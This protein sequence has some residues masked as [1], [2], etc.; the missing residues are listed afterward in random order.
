MW[1]M[2]YGHNGEYTPCAINKWIRPQKTNKNTDARFLWANQNK[3]GKQKKDNA[4]RQPTA[5]SAPL[6]SKSPGDQLVRGHEGRERPADAFMISQSFPIIYAAPTDVTEAELINTRSQPEACGRLCD[7]SD[8]GTLWTSH[9]L[10]FAPSIDV[11]QWNIRL[12]GKRFSWSGLTHWHTF[13][14]QM[15]LR[16]LLTSLLRVFFSASEFLLLFSKRKIKCFDPFSPLPPNS[17]SSIFSS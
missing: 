16:R 2:Q 9:R 12:Q 8:V 1:P 6:L 4:S 11:R 17:R 14:E 7:L 3:T 15:V 13:S 5:A 10:F